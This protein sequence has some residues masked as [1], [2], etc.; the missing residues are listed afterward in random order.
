[1]KLRM[2]FES[3]FM[4]NHYI[5][6]IKINLKLAEKRN[7]KGGMALGQA[8]GDIGLIKQ[9]KPDQAS[10]AEIQKLEIQANELSK[11]YA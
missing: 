5:E 3:Q 10:S 8:I 4:I 2:I 1:M 11:L 6:Q 7:G 9:L